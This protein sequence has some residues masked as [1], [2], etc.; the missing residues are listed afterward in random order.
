MEI[1]LDGGMP[2]H[3]VLVLRYIRRREDW[4]GQL[5]KDAVELASGDGWRYLSFLML[6][7]RHVSLREETLKKWKKRSDG[8]G[9]VRKLPCY[10]FFLARYT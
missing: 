1:S 6:S 2:G 9:L 4:E 7:E 8:L 10:L 3:S 5:A